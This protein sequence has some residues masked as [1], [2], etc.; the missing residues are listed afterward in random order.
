MDIPQSYIDKFQ[1]KK[2]FNPEQETANDIYEYFGKKMNY[3]L[4]RRLIKTKGLIF[5]QQTFLEVKKSDFVNKPALFMKMI[6]QTK[7][8]YE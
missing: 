6:G 3:G 8:N 4:I 5:V 7:I 2:K 1:F